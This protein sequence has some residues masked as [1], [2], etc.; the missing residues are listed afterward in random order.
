ML[1]SIDYVGISAVIAAAAAAAVSVIGALAS[2]QAKKNTATSNGRTL[3]Q[4]A[5]HAEA[6]A[7]DTNAKVTKAADD[8]A[9]G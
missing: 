6:T 9:A 1:A 2:L 8:L 3:G 4:L 7:V 5:E